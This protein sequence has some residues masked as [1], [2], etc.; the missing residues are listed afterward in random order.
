MQIE[1]P[2]SPSTVVKRNKSK[3]KIRGRVHSLS[4]RESYATLLVEES[5]EKISEED[6]KRAEAAAR[7]R[8]SSLEGDRI[9]RRSLSP[10][11]PTDVTSA[12]LQTLKE[13]EVEEETKVRGN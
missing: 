3:P 12:G 5:I 13:E 4:K 9:K 10:L 2:D 1:I 11:S 6:S 7:V 8:K